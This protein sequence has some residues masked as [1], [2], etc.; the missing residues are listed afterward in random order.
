[1]VSA[2]ETRTPLR[3]SSAVNSTTFASIG[4]ALV[5][6]VLVARRPLELGALELQVLLQLL[7]GLAD[8]A[9]VLEDDRQRVLHQL[10]LEGVD[11][12]ERERLRPVE[13]FAAGRHLPQT[14]LA[15]PLEARDHRGRRPPPTPRAPP[16]P[17]RQ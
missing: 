5:Q 10:V 16:P 4:G 8:V 15:G 11:V 14:E 7:L 1:M 3:R 6:D 12:E 17:A 9:L 2:S 13:R